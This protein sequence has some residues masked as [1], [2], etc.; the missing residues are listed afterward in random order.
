MNK[1]TILYVMLSIAISFLIIFFS[2]N[3]TSKEAKE[4]YRVYLKG[5]SLGLIS[6]KE[7]LEEY[8]DNKQQKVKEDYGVKRVYAPADLDIEK[9]VTYDGRLTTIESIYK[10]IEHISPFTIEGYR[11]NIK[12]LTTTNSE[13]KKEKAKDFNIYVLD[14]NTFK[15]ASVN[16]V[17]SF[18]TEDRY[19]AFA[20]NNQKEITE[21][22]TI[23]E[24]IYIK[25]KVSIKKERIP[26]NKEIYTD[27]SD[28][29]KIL[30]FGTLDE[31]AKYV[32]KSGDTIEDI[33]F[34]NKIS[35]EEFL[36]ANPNF[37]DKDSLLFEGQE[38]TIGLIQPKFSVVEE[39][40][41][42]VDQEVNYETE[43]R[44]DNS[45]NKSYSVIEQN[46]VK[47]KNRLTQKIQK[48]NGEITNVVT[49]TT[50]QLVEPIKEVIV[51]GG[52]EET[53]Y[54]SGY[55]TIVPTKGEWG[56]PATCSTISSPFGYRWG[57]LHNGTDIAGCGYGS[58][59]FAAQAGTVVTV[60]TKAVDG[61]YITI[62]HH[63][64]YYT[65]YCHLAGQLVREGQN[66][67]KG[68]VIGTMGKSGYATGVHVHFAMWKGF[69]YR[70]GTALNAMM[71][72]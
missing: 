64:G 25:N 68:Q 58:S 5:K 46:G 42:V 61:N 37:K 1:R 53:Y 66:V 39:D 9:E 62:D 21:T 20:N 72:Y 59:I 26:I 10:K 4:V 3:N 32:V 35:S 11:I 22:G 17:K 71:F 47:G 70:G 34:N 54:G 60:A 24:N 2:N 12:G 28:L 40:H 45:K 41:T 65:M 7:Q 63:N 27:E 23:I 50:E 51:R 19:N 15:K 8:I 33:S 48:I 55:G 13:G 14:K 67:E 29:S 52:K 56:W 30:L 44:Y 36:I 6:S 38:V 69:P 57:Y 18:I 16:T 49:V 43:V 31:Q